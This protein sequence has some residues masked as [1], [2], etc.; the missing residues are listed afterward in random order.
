[1]PTNRHNSSTFVACVVFLLS[2]WPALP[3]TAQGVL[4]IDTL[5]RSVAPNIVNYE[6]LGVRDDTVIIWTGG[7]TGFPNHTALHST[8]GGRTFKEV[9]TIPTD[10]DSPR[11]RKG[12]SRARLYPNSSRSTFITRD[13]VNFVEQRVADYLDVPY[14]HQ[15]LIH[16]THP[17]TTFLIFQGEK[18]I[19]DNYREWLF[20]RFNDNDQWTPMKVPFH[21]QG[22]SRRLTVNFDYARPSRIYVS[23]D[24]EDWGSAGGWNGTKYEFH[25]TDDWGETWTK[26][27]KHPLDL[28]YGT[29]CRGYDCG[30]Q[31]GL[32]KPDHS[33]THIP[34]G[35]RGIRVPVVKNHITGAID[36]TMGKSLIALVDTLLPDGLD[37]VRKVRFEFH[38]FLSVDCLDVRNVVFWYDQI[39]N[40]KAVTR[41]LNVLTTNGGISWFHH[42]NCKSQT[43]ENISLQ[44]SASTQYACS[45]HT[46]FASH[47]R[48]R[49]TSN[50]SS[51]IYETAILRISLNPIKTSIKLSSD[52]LNF[53]AI[54]PNPASELA[55]VTL[56]RAG[57]IDPDKV[58]IV[59]A[60][61][62]DDCHS[63]TI[64]TQTERSFTI[65]VRH[66]AAG[67][68][69]VILNVAGQMESLPL[70]VQW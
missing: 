30:D 17:D 43:G 28:P 1:M 62:R 50:G 32:P 2:L 27:A 70:V 38:R 67:M 69:R 33:I 45:T 40:G 7:G 65:D 54:H 23:I 34:M 47:P 19:W 10:Y 15:Y 14:A 44:V 60:L 53:V 35:D 52:L 68:Y 42:L 56:N 29:P 58:R 46:M 55:T 11:P 36:S 41:G 39:A 57:M 59:D 13:G 49:P 18:S 25:M 21:R 63:V 6:I 8:D 16:P 12:L 24:G 4:K 31:I 61:G 37:S 26:L 9:T 64:A 51:E 66:L 5:F 48:T 3:A 22:Y 20:Y